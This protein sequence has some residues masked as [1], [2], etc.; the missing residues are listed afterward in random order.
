VVQLLFRRVGG[1]NAALG[2]GNIGHLIANLADQ[3]RLLQPLFCLL[4]PA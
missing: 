2:A 4:A 1:A 3:L